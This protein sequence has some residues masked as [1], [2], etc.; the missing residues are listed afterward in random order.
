MTRVRA[1]DLSRAGRRLQRKVDTRAVKP[2]IL[3]V[4][5]GKKTEPQ[6]FRGFRITSINVVPAS[7]IHLSVVRRAIKELEA[8]SDYEQVW[9]VFD[10]DKQPSKPTDQEQYNNAISLAR[11]NNI[12]VAYSNDAFELWYLLHFGYYDTRLSRADYVDR[13]NSLVAGGYN[14]NDPKMYEKLEPKMQ[15]AIRNA[16]RLYNASDQNDIENQDPSTAIFRLVE[17]LLKHV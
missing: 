5:E 8:D 16:K 6:Y 17:E 1:W 9:C 10:R 4:C 14:K 11:Q 2:R 12:K 3:I 13:L 15:D 7:A